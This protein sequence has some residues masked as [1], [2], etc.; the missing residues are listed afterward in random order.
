MGLILL[1]EKKLI[2]ANHNLEEMA[3]LIGADSLAYISLDGLY[4]SERGS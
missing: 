4:R 3:R 2:V 1:I